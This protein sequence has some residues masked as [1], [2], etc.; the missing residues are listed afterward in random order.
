MKFG[1]ADT[2]V[3]AVVRREV[4]VVVLDGVVVGV[5]GVVGGGSGGVVPS[6]IGNATVSFQLSAGTSTSRTQSSTA[7]STSVP[8]TVI[9]RWAITHGA[10]VPSSSAHPLIAVSS[11]QAKP[12]SSPA[13]RHWRMK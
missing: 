13:S 12:V 7:Q 2:G 11:S 6:L 3:A 4:V 5:V 8:A 9:V 10:I 1:V